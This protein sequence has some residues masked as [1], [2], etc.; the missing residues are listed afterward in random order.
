MRMDGR[1]QS[2]N[3]VDRRGISGKTKLGIGGGIVGIIV[4]AAVT[5]LSGGSLGDVLG[6]VM[7]HDE[8]I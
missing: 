5:L 8:P 3:M 2:G 1:R 7:G 4:V 6:N